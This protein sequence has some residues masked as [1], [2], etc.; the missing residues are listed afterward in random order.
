[1][2]SLSRAI[3]LTTLLGVSTTACYGKFMLTR[4][5]YE[6]NGKV[7]DNKF[8]HSLVMWVFMIVPVYFLAGVADVV[9]LNLVEFW[10]GTNPMGAEVT[11]DDGTKVT[12]KHEVKNGLNTMTLTAMKDGKLLR[13]VVL[14]KKGESV[15][16]VSF[17]GAGKQLDHKVFA[18]V[19][20]SAEALA[21]ATL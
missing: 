12:M 18:G 1:M 20:V 10:T 21:S 4:K 13:T 3:A 8:V 7:T 6:I 17:D 9:I 2:K 19:D 15:D 5:V 11:T 14:T 16:A